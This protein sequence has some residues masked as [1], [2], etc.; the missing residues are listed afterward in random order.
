MVRMREEETSLLGCAILSAVA[1]E[2]YGSIDEAVTSM[3]KTGKTF[4]PNT[5]NRGV[6]DRHFRLY[7]RLY[8]AL[9]P[10]FRQ[11]V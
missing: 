1:V 2:D 11:F 10:V 3:V 8:E 4:I 6:Y 5:G 9:K 7:A